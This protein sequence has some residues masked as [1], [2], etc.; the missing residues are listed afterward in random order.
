MI[1]Y[2]CLIFQP[3]L[4]LT[5]L[6]A[7]LLIVCLVTGVQ[8]S[9]SQYYLR[10]ELKDEAGNGIGGARIA[11]A[12]KGNYPFFT[13]STGAFGI[14]TNVKVDT[15]TFMH[16]GYDTLKTVV[17]TS[18]LGSFVMKG[19]VKKTTSTNYLSSLIKNHRINL[20]DLPDE[21]GELYSSTVENPVVNAATF[22][23]AAIALHMNKASYG[24]VRKTLSNREKPAI[25]AVKIEELLNYFAFKPTTPVDQDKTF[26]FSSNL[27]SCPWNNQNQLLFINLKAK[28]INLDKTPPAN[29]V[30]LIDV[31]GSM[32]MENRLP[33][34]KSAFKLLTENLRPK[35]LVTIVTYGD[36]VTE[37]LKA[38]PGENKQVIIEAIEGLRPNGS[39][40]GAS[41]IQTA[42]RLARSTFIPNGNNRVILATDGDFN[43]GMTSDKQ[44]ED[45]VERESKSGVSLT[46]LG[47]GIGI[48]DSKIEGLAKKGN[49]NFAYI[50]NEAEAEKVLVEEFAQRLY[51]VASN[52]FMD[53][54]FNPAAVKEYR[55]IGFDN[56]KSAIA[57][58]LDKVDGGEIGSGQSMMAVFEITPTA[59][60]TAPAASVELAYKLPVGNE[61]IK[62][63]FET[64]LNYQPIENADSSLRL[65]ASII[66]FGTLL[67]QS[68][69]A[70]EFSWDDLHNIASA[71][72]TP[73]NLIQKEFIDLIVKAKKLYPNKVRRKFAKS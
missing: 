70:K 48:K 33:L 5:M 6:K 24:N 10:G 67:K 68:E 55:L 43:V 65:A 60:V 11:L 44:L 26:A 69:F 32:D 17:V 54:K 37:L 57:E 13:G 71:S 25:D 64:L 56:K 4:N 19:Q 28:K 3:P 22:P 18:Q 53:I 39:T 30:F 7:L 46:C 12:S 16:E 40:P 41:A 52:A 15:V 38:T 31:S 8:N 34:I 21:K 58:R 42:Y 59:N 51:A 20:N 49:G 23:E 29:L 66:M 47:F 27:T 2:C 61:T 45:L 36:V 73:G 35:D 62:E 1:I 9:F 72:V 50:N 63:R 14:P